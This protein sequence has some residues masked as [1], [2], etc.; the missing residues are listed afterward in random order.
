MLT[1]LKTHLAKREREEMSIEGFRKAAVLVP[2][3]E[4]PAGLELLFT[5]RSSELRSHAG[6][7]AFPGGRLDEGESLVEAACRETQEEIGVSVQEA[8][9]LGFL[10]DHPSPAKYVVTPVVAVLPWPQ[11][12]QL[13]EAEVEEV[14]TVPLDDL[15]LL[16]P[17]AEERSMKHY[18]RLLHFYDY[19]QYSIWGLTANVMKNLFEAWQLKHAVS[20]QSLSNT[21]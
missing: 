18:K 12:L 2:I 4:T 6:Q 3:L 7:I 10:D 13:N 5:V 8:A 17:R 20:D 14:F 19:K 15:L 21:Q 9:V 16:K 11:R 1:E